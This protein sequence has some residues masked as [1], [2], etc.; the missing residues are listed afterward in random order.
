MI[1]VSV[2]KHSLSASLCPTTQR[3][4]LQSSPWFG[5]LKTNTPV[6]FSGE[7]LFFTDTGSVPWVHSRYASD[8]WRRR[9]ICIIVDVI[10]HVLCYLLCYCSWRQCRTV[11]VRNAAGNLLDG[12]SC[13]M[14]WFA[15]THVNL[16]TCAIWEFDY[17]SINYNSNNNL[18]FKRHM[19]IHPSAN[20][21]ICIYIYTY[22]HIWHI[23]IY[24]YTQ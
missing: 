2:K 18:K 12:C 14:A 20:T 22:T 15:A 1:S 4:K 23:Y 9:I 24:I 16:R 21:Y 17:N 10:V 8:P 7:M 5:D 6:L 3:Q 11:D 13:G 19:E